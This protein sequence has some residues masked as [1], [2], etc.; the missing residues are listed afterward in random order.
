[1]IELRNVTKKFGSF[2]AVDNISLVVPAGEFFG[3][4]G[5]NGAGKT[6]ALR[7]LTGSRTSTERGWKQ[8]VSLQAW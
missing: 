5:P 2:T 4:L 8:V 7:M 6:T 1:M 3:F